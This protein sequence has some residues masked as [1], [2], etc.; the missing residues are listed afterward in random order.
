MGLTLPVIPRLDLNQTRLP[1]A[2]WLMFKALT[3][4]LVAKLHIS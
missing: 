3:G 1:D 2:G 4:S